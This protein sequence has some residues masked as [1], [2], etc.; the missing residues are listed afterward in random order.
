MPVDT[1]G[2]ASA[3]NAETSWPRSA[4][5]SLDEPGE[6]DELTSQSSAGHHRSFLF[7]FAD[8]QR[9]GEFSFFV[10]L[11]IQ[12]ALHELGHDIF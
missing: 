4:S 3:R 12:Y 5:W 6:M 9:I 8:S 10:G 7:N 2:V 1:G 11:H